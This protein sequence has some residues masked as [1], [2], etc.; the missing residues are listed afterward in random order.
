MGL[1]ARGCRHPGTLPQL[2]GFPMCTGSSRRCDMPGSQ[3]EDAGMAVGRGGGAQ[4]RGDGRCTE[5]VSPEICVSS[6]SMFFDSFPQ[7]A[8]RYLLNLAT[9]LRW[10]RQ[11]WGLRAFCCRGVYAW[12]LRAL[13]THLHTWHTCLC[14]ATRRARLLLPPLG[15]S[16]AEEMHSVCAA[17][18]PVPQSLHS[19]QVLCACSDCTRFCPTQSAPCMD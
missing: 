10:E 7:L 2:R 14:T 4:P 11:V 17:A 19:H 9:A 13:H 1:S 12:G 8:V 3:P 16:C 6:F 15:V 18:A 5:F